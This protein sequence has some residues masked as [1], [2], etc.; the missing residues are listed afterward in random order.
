MP[1]TADE[2]RRVALE[3][4][5]SS[6]YHAT[7][8]QHIAEVA[9]V[10]KASVLYHYSSK[11]VL[12]EAAL[13]PAIDRLGEILDAAGPQP[14]HEGGL[15]L[16]PGVRRGRRIGAARH[17]HSGAGPRSGRA[18]IGS[19]QA[20]HDRFARFG[21]GRLRNGRGSRSACRSIQRSEH[22]G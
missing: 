6:G 7:S 15:G 17:G 13:S 9:G 21:A 5:A 10:S 2:L 20:H 22:S 1:A 18:W 3:L 4:F 19:I 16:L 11:E 14:K 8:L 12:L